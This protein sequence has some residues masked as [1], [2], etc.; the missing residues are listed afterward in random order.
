MKR[1]EYKYIVELS[2]YN[3]QERTIYIDD[4]NNYVY[5]W[6][7]R[8][9]EIY[10][11]QYDFV[12]IPI[13]KMTRGMLNEYTKS[14]YKNLKSWLERSKEQEHKLDEYRKFIDMFIPKNSLAGL[15]KL[16]EKLDGYEVN[17]DLFDD[18]K[19]ESVGK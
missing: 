4:N 3:K 19:Y 1:T 11:H 13:E 15:E 12:T 16:D 17:I 7:N 14:L 2:R 18:E 10:D 5:K 8:I 9:F 6:D